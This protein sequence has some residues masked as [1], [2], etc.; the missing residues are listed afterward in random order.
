[1]SPAPLP[2]PSTGSG[3][4]PSINEPHIQ[5]YYVRES[6][7]W[8]VEQKRMAHAQAL[9]TVGEYAMFTLMWHVEDYEAGFVEHCPVCYGED[10]PTDI[11]R[12]V[13]DT[14]SQPEQ[15]RCPECFGTTFEG[16]YKAQ[17]IR[18]AIF[19]DAD[20]DEQKMARGVANPQDLSVES[21]PDFRVRSGD[22]VF[23]GNG[24][25]FQLRVPNRVTL[26]TGFEI[27]HQSSMAIGYNHTRANQEAL[28]SVAYVIP[29]TADALDAILTQVS[30][31]PQK[32]D[33]FEVIRAPLIPPNND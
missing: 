2:I 5:P 1:M 14:Y 30:R 21:T 32:F 31:A 11:K 8:A 17:I 9:W 29:P 4:P 27:P 28:T 6:Q 7:A 25:R 16:G 13:A 26:R 18:P 12:R 23:R 3:N 33:D 24:D 19:S 20:E 22:Y 10:D 15:H